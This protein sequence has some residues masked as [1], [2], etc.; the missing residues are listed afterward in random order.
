MYTDV[1]LL[2]VA[3][4]HLTSIEQLD[5]FGSYTKRF[6]ELK[7][8]RMYIKRGDLESA[9][10]M[11][12]GKL[13]PY[14]ED[15]SN[16][17]GLSDALKTVINSVYGLTSAKFDNSFKDPKNIDNIVAKRGALFMVDLKHFV[18]ERGFTVAHIKTDSIKIPNAT[19]EIIDE[20]MEFGREYGYDFEHE[21]T[22]EKF[23]LVNDAVYIAKTKAGRKPAQWTATG[24]Q[25]QEPYVFKTLFSREPVVFKDLCQTKTANSPLYLDFS[26]EDTPMV[27][28]DG[29]LKRFVG[30]AGSFVPILPG[31]GGGILT[32]VT[33]GKDFAV[34]GTT[35]YRWMEA[36]QCIALGKQKDVDMSYFVKLADKAIDKISQ[37]GDF[38]Q[39]RA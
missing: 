38:E 32:R 4:M 34:S 13:Q 14:L 18:Q 11:L 28:E 15:E 7:Q 26:G 10:K 21:A 30:K 1:A 24:A 6:S 39:F 16:L 23:C 20:V 37:Y 12:N 3:S 27:F 9:R 25:F 22:Y 5:L 35:G 2:D 29:D 17:G 36:E 33:D 19:K 31:R 8:A